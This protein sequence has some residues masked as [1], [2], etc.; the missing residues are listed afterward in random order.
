MDSPGSQ[1]PTTWPTGVAAR[2]SLDDIDSRGRRFFPA[3]AFAALPRRGADLRLDWTEHSH[4]ARLA[5][6]SQKQGID[7]EAKTRSPKLEFGPKSRTVT[8]NAEG[9]SNT[10]AQYRS[11]GVVRHRTSPHLMLSPNEHAERPP[12]GNSSIFL[13]RIVSSMFM[14]VNAWCAHQ[15]RPP[16]TRR[17]LSLVAK[18]FVTDQE[19]PEGPRPTRRA[20]SAWHLP[21]RQESGRRQPDV[22]LFTS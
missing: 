11:W 2:T 16:P 20:K 5:R 15:V 6:G 13:R 14:R 12:R 19:E 3:G 8:S 1:C 4:C 17:T 21:P 18:P 10:G 7:E 9:F 22:A